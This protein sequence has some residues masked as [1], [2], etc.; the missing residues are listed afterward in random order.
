MLG[1]RWLLPT[2]STDIRYVRHSANNNHNNRNYLIS[3]TVYNSCAEYA[4]SIQININNSDRLQR[5]SRDN[6]NI[7][8]V[9]ITIDR[10]G[11]VVASRGL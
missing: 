5:G 3:F 1:M 8:L 2:T 4:A 10:L 9:K 11:N 7:T 6:Y